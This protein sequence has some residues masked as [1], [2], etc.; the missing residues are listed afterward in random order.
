[1]KLCENY[2]VKISKETANAILVDLDK[3]K[4]NKIKMQLTSRLAK[5]LM[6]Q[7][8]FDIAHDI[9][10]KIGNLKKAMKCCIK[11]GDKKKVI[12]FAHNCRIPELYILAANFLMNLDWTN[13]IV[14]IIVSFF[15]KAKAYYNLA[16]FYT[17]FASVQINEKGNYNQAEEL[18]EN[19]IKTVQKVREN[20][21]KK[22]NKISE[23]QMKLDFIHRINEV[24]QKMKENKITDSIKLCNELLN[25]NNCDDILSE[26]EIYGMLINLYNI[27]KD[28]NEAYEVL[29]KGKQKNYTNLNKPEIILEILK[30]VGKENEIKNFVSN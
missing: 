5:L 30:N 28:F 15:N 12:E 14:K 1:M 10:V 9:Y 29:L 21:E 23:L 13:E 26:R 19:A 2:K 25:V 22:D 7:G 4:D 6:T 11:M 18:Y 16:S 20:D 24:N 8:E 27:N 3:E 17:V